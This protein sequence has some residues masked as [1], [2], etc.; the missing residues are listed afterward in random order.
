MKAYKFNPALKFIK[1][2]INGN[3]Y[4]NGQF[5]F[6]DKIEKIPYQNLIK[7]LLHGNPQRREKNQD[8]FVPAIVS[9]NEFI[10]DQKSKIVWLGHSSF[11]IQIDKIRI[12][13]DP[14]F[15]ALAPVRMHRKHGL[16]CHISDLQNI[17]YILLSHGHR[18]HLDIPSLRKILKYNPNVEVLCPL[19]FERMLQKIGFQKIQEAAWWQRYNTKDIKIDFLPAKH[20]NRRHILDFNTT[21]WG[22]FAIQHQDLKIYFA[23][24]TAYESH[25]KEIQQHYQDFDIALMPIGAYKPKFIMEW[26][27]T[28][29]EEAVMASNDLQAKIFIPMHYGTYDLSDEPASEPIKIIQNQ[30]QEKRL[31]ARLEILDVGEAFLLN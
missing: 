24:D 15:F 8:K 28:S 2:N 23:G 7:W 18:D 10:K 14:V 27:H 17:D 25:F 1:E 29:P 4:I 30:K 13:T 11:Y 20:W 3:L 12:L 19:G 16:P 21:L 31:E 22:S 26:A 6:K 5:V 9:N